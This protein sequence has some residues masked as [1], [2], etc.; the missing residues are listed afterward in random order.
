MNKTLSALAAL[1]LLAVC[2][3]SATLSSTNFAWP[4]NA[5]SDDDLMLG[6]N[7]NRP[8]PFKTVSALVRNV[9]SNRVARGSWQFNGFPFTNAPLIVMSNTLALWHFS[10]NGHLQPLVNKALII[11]DESRNML[12]LAV[13]SFAF[14]LSS[15]QAGG[16]LQMDNGGMRWGG[17]HLTNDASN[18]NLILSPSVAGTAVRL[19]FGRASDAAT[20]RINNRVTGEM[21][22]ESASGLTNIFLEVGGLFLSATNGLRFSKDVQLASAAKDVGLRRQTEHWL[23]VTDGTNNALPSGVAFGNL[24]AKILASSVLTNYGSAH[25]PTNT[26]ALFELTANFSTG[27]H[28]TNGA[29]RAFVQQDFVIICDAGEDSTI[30][31]E[32]DV[33]ADGTYDK[34][35]ASVSF[36]GPPSGSQTMTGNLSAFIGPGWR[37]RFVQANTG[38]P[39][40]TKTGVGQ[41][42]LW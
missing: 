2:S 13:Q 20:H 18:P 1:L 24:R 27:T 6:E 9:F 10:T 36:S 25:L 26:A 7:T 19:Y 29:Q 5:F 23:E 41:W 4:T 38:T 40:V 33:A 42:I 12:P 3:H 35:V 17:V 11:G 21:S 8:T 32:V 22:F 39:V 30:D 31:L 14:E 28:Y 37:F 34:K 15:S 16:Y